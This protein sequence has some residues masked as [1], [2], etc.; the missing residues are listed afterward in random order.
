M[1]VSYTRERQEQQRSCR[2]VRWARVETL[3]PMKY[4]RSFHT[5]RY[6]SICRLVLRVILVLLSIPGCPLVSIL[7]QW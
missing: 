4:V 1:L 7:I 6:K 3:K 5:Y 2:G